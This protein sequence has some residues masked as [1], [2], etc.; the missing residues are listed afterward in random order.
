MTTQPLQID[1]IAFAT[2]AEHLQGALSL[3]ALPRL[4]ELLTSKMPAPALAAENLAANQD[5]A[6]EVEFQLSGEKNVMGQH[7]LHLSIQ[8]DL[9]T[10]CQRCLQRMRIA[11]GLNFT[12][13]IAEV[14]DAALLDGDELTLEDE[15]DVQPP[16]QAMS[17]LALIEDE[18]IMALPIAPT[19]DFSCTDVQ[20]QSGDKHNPFAALKG[21]I[22]S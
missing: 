21:L 16:D 12:Y 7:L 18:L 22:K 5:V 1:N 10:F 19:H 4:R 9:P 6:D 15:M 20:M 17:L 3:A 2:R 8:A 11:M 13:L 14:D